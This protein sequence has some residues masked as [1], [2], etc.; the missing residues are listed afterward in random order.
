M[1]S[2]DSSSAHCYGL[3]QCFQISVAKRMYQGTLEGSQSGSQMGCLVEQT[4]RDGDCAGPHIRSLDPLAHD[5]LYYLAK[6]TVSMVEETAMMKIVSAQSK[7]WDC[8][9]ETGV[10]LRYLDSSSW[11]HW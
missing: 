3:A 9:R 10:Q 2:P 7:V 4:P 11:H 5:G 6:K 8:P 1:G